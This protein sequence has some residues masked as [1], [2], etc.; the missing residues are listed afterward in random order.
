MV[1]L[2]SLSQKRR[3]QKLIL[4]VLQLYSTGHS[5]LTISDKLG[6]STWVIQRILAQINHDAALE[7]KTM[8]QEIPIQ[9]KASI[10]LLRSVIRTCDEIRNTSGIQSIKLGC[11]NLQVHCLQQ[12]NLLYADS[13][14]LGLAIKQ[15][16]SR[17][18]I[19]NV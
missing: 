15:A 8:T 6:T 7:L 16:T 12:I 10:T 5:Y 2:L 11:L 13:E 9:F 19:R 4:Q 3:K 17:E 18:H 1:Y 14:K